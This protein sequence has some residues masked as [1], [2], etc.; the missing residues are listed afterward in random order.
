MSRPRP[1]TPADQV[2]PDA[3]QALRAERYDQMLRLAD[4]FDD[5]GEQMRTWAKA[6]ADVLADP[7][8]GASAALSPATYAEAEEE[9]RAATTGRNGLLSRS[10]E[11]D[12]DA[13]VLRATVL[14][15]QWIDDLRAAAY[16]TLGSIAGKAIGYLAP[17]V[18]LGGA[19]VSAGLIETDALDREGIA[20][21]LSELAEANPD[22]M[23]HIT[24]GGGLVDSLQMRS[25]L[26]AG[27]LAGDGGGLT[28]EGGLRAA[29]VERLDTGFGAAL[30]DTAVGLDAPEAVLTSAAPASGAAALPR[31]LE[32]LF[33]RL[34]GTRDPVRIVPA[35]GARHIVYLSGAP[36][37]GA[38]LVAG[39]VA[40]YVDDAVRT[41]AAE[42]GNPDDPVHVLLVGCG[43]GG[44]AAVTIAARA[45]LPGFVVDRV[46]AADAPATQMVRL[47]DSVRVLALEDRSDPVALL[48]SLVN[49]SAANR[50]TVVYDSATVGSDTSPAYVGG[51]RAADASA[52]PDLVAEIDALRELGYLA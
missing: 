23:E 29:G 19:I 9:L 41:I 7:D 28:R 20:A 13:L 33:V 18:A 26:T 31:G 2:R 14:T 6:G 16:L 51:A 1:T 10:I 21:Y 36:S 22:L 47:P 48:G 45:D 37:G 5:A 52:H 42:I 12:A 17:E 46:V 35:T 43:T 15:Y 25:L 50:T 27:V 3:Q 11:L 34:A 30:R 4:L 32:E 24:T 49:A 38:R 40:P 8:V 39:D 44:V